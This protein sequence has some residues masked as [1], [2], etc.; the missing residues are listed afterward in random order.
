MNIEIES[1]L[2]RKT[3]TSSIGSNLSS[4]RRQVIC[5]ARGLSQSH[6]AN[7]AVI[8]IPDNAPHGLL[9]TCSN[10]ECAGSQRKFRYCKSK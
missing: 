7:T 6:N 5:Q 9:L 10:A 4:E 3:E 8:E 1:I 2:R